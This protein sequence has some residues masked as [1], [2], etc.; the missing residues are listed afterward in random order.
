M[1]WLLQADLGGAGAAPAIAG[2]ACRRA[3]T[4]ERG[5]C[6]M[7]NP[8]TTYISRRTSE[9]MHVFYC[10]RDG[11]YAGTNVFIIGADA[12]RSHGR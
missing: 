7:S 12:V 8:T 9:R 11:L 6:I 2:R 10:E 4:R 1:Y 5:K 3:G